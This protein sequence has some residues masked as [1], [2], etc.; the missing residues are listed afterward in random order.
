MTGAMLLITV[1]DT[2]IKTVSESLPAA[3]TIA[4]RGLFATGFILMAVLAAGLHRQIRGVLE[5]RTAGRALLD[6]ASTFTYLYAL[7]Q[8]PLAEAVAINMVVPLIVVALAVVFLGEQVR[9]QRWAA[10][11]VGFAGM[12]LVVRPGGN[13]FTWWA[14]LCMIG[15]VLNAL[16]DI[17]TRWIPPVVPSLIITLATSLAVTATGLV[18][19]TLEGWKPVGATNLGLLAGAAA[20]LAG[21]YYL[22]ILSMRVGEVSMV[23]GFRYSALP[24]A[25]LLGWAVWGHLPDAVASLGMLVV[26][27]AGLYLL[28]RDKGERA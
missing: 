7:F 9:W 26:V 25:A 21:G 15:T 19:T 20:F 6:V 23:S 2:M 8:M 14:V 16:R 27:A 17:Y 5:R 4:V 18:L 22:T 1:N 11:L 28:R 10:V 24:A 3:Q 13:A 12:L